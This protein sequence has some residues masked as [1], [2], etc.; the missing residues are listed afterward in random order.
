M[1]GWARK[2][3]GT[4]RGNRALQYAFLTGV[5]ALAIMSSAVGFA[6]SVTHYLASKPPAGLFD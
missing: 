3:K 6:S 4:E 2:T 5:L 1:R